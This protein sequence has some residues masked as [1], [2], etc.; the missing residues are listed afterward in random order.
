[1]SGTGGARHD[2][3]QA[4]ELR[5]LTFQRYFTTASPGSVLVTAGQTIVL[6]TASISEEVPPWR[7]GQG[8]GWLTAE[9][10][11]LPGSTQPRKARD[12]G[13]KLDGRTSEIQRLIG[14]SL[15]A[16][17]QLEK[18]GERTLMLDC[19]VLQADGGTR[20]ASINGALVACIDALLAVG[21]APAEVLTDSVG[22]ISVGLG[23]AGALTDLDYVEDVAAAVDMNLVMTGRG[24]Y[25]E[26]QGTGE[27][28]T[29]SDEQLSQ[30][31][32][33]GR[34]S[35]GQITRLQAAALGELWPFAT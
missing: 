34:V 20:T 2:G 13:P 22:A 21:L 3:R 18:L 23:T 28:S 9:Y 35:I 4:D 6:C 12:R 19:D 29:F 24:Q 32:R 27:E 15:R 8:V 1:M 26:I 25:V 7:K 31:L 33:L 5:P 16:V 11:M 30:L 10:S 17:V 14:R